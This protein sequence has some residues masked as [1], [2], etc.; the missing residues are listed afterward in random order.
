M[1]CDIGEQQQREFLKKATGNTASSLSGA[2][3]HAAYHEAIQ[4]AFH[5]ESFHLKEMLLTTPAQEILTQ[6]Q[7]WTLAQDDDF[8]VR[9]MAIDTGRLTT[10]QC[11]QIIAQDPH[12]MP[13]RA[14]V[15][16]GGLSRERLEELTSCPDANLRAGAVASGGLGDD[17]VRI[18]A[19]HDNDWEVRQTCIGSGQLDEATLINVVR[20]DVYRT[21]QAEAVRELLE[22]HGEALAEILTL[23]SM[24]GPD[25]LMQ[26][27]EAAHTVTPRPEQEAYAR[28][29]IQR[30]GVDTDDARRDLRRTLREGLDDETLRIAQDWLRNQRG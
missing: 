28:W 19:L 27:Q 12:D 9:T 3:L 24:V 2:A 6:E 17:L 7:I 26:H 25:E 29:L 16:F 5:S 20:E 30:W 15:I 21:N 11:E 4:D 13:K 8:L 1:S 22:R 10:E 14:A 18:M 23:D